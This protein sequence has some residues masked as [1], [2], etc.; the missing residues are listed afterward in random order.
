MSGDG[1][2]PRVEELGELEGEGSMQV[3]KIDDGGGS[4]GAPATLEL[5]PGRLGVVNL[6]RD[7]L[8]EPMANQKRKKEGRR[9]LSFTDS[10]DDKAAVDEQRRRQWRRGCSSVC[11]CNVRAKGQ[12]VARA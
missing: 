12:A 4:G 9:G 1:F 8:G 7:K 2:S 5:A 11:A 10:G 6:R 3:T